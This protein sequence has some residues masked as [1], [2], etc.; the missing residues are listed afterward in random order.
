MSDLIKDN[1]EGL[2]TLEALLRNGCELKWQFDRWWI[3][4]K[5]GCGL[6]SGLT[7]KDLVLTLGGTHERPD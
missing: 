3:F 5:K 7:L 6:C 2:L 1:L 4:D